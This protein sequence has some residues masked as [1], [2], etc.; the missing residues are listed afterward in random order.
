[1]AG[2]YTGTMPRIS[3]IAALFAS[4]AVSAQGNDE[5]YFRQ[6]VAPVLE[7]RCV[8]CHQGEKPKGGLD[9]TTHQTAIAGGQSGPSWQIGKPDES[10]L[11][12]Y[13]SGD[14]PEMP[15]DGPPLSLRKCWCFGVGL[16]KALP[17]PAGLMLRDR[18]SID[19]TGGRS[20]R[21]RK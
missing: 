21:W 10:L 6:Q 9:L 5:N 3:I 2:C 13:V 1:M 16:P 14:K 4:L 19:A 7:R 12:E 8:G 18:K 11:I 15:K 17:W 20:C